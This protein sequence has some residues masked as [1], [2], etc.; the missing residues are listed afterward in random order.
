MGGNSGTK[1]KKKGEATGPVQK[2]KE[3]SVLDASLRNLWGGAFRS[4]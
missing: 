1:K 4:E 2:E 3:V